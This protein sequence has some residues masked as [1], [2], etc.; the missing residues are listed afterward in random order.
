MTIVPDQRRAEIEADG[1]GVR[2]IWTLDESGLGPTIEE[3]A[4]LFLEL[5]ARFPGYRLG[6]LEIDCEAGLQP[7]FAAIVDYYNP[8]TNL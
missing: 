5:A 4:S 7:P 2:I 3:T 1:D 6:D 8:E